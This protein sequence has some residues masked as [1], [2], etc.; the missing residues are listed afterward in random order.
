MTVLKGELSLFSFFLKEEE[1]SRHQEARHLLERFFLG[2]S[3]YSLSSFPL[4]ERRAAETGFFDIYIQGSKCNF[5][6]WDSETEKEKEF[7]LS[8]KRK[9]FPAVLSSSFP[10][11]KRGARGGG[12]RAKG[13]KIDQATKSA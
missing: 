5:E 6:S 4:S 9:N 2:R 13:K 10:L 3:S 7:Q 1:A 8:Q 12:R 11:E